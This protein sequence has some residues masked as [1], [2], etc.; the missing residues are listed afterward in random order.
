MQHLCLKPFLGFTLC[1][2]LL[3]NTH[4]FCQVWKESR[5]LQCQDHTQYYSDLVQGC[6]GVGSILYI[7]Y[8]ISVFLLWQSRIS[9]SRV[10]Q[11]HHDSPSNKLPPDARR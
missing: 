8:A 9:G 11:S 1:Y 2:V 6:V 7:I 3:L 4:H 10:R 5:N